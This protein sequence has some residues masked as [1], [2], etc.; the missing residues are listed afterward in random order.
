[1]N[2][3]VNYTNK[4]SFVELGKEIMRKVKNI[5]REISDKDFIEEAGT[6]LLSFGY[7]YDFHKIF[8]VENY[9]NNPEDVLLSYETE[10]L[11]FIS[12]VDKN[13]EELSARKNLKK[14]FILV[15][16]YLGSYLDVA[17]K[18]NLIQ[19][20]SY[21]F[22]IN[23]L[24]LLG[25]EQENNKFALLG[26]IQKLKDLSK[27]KAEDFKIMPEGFQFSIGGADG[28]KVVADLN[29]IISELESI[30]AE[31][32]EDPEVKEEPKKELSITEIVDQ[33]MKNLD[34]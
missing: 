23:S 19:D 13:L 28:K 8:N 12:R 32:P 15:A 29:I 11:D 22:N 5:D 31:K 16:S 25:L 7:E 18:E 10:N 3:I 30:M 17:L 14:D 33:N 34:I 20:S 1:M 9:E 6:N 4:K 27:T 21:F 26:Y 2:I 24:A